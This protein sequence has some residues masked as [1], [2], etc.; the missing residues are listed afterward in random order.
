MKRIM[1]MTSLIIV[2]ITGSVLA[3]PNEP[4]G[5]R[6]YKW[7]MHENEVASRLGNDMLGKPSLILKKKS[8]PIKLANSYIS[9]AM[10]S[11][12]RLGLG[13]AMFWFFDGMLS[14]VTLHLV[15]PIL[16]NDVYE[17]RELVKKNIVK[18]YGPP[19]IMPP[20]SGK[21]KIAYVWKGK[22]TSIRLWILDD[23]TVYDSPQLL[24]NIYS[25]SLDKVEKE[26][27]DALGRNKELQGW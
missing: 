9:G 4:D 7:G 16:N 13:C 6:Q 18:L 14:N 17:L 21:D 22:V 24:L 26:Y 27:L 3:F 11:H 2:V 15:N 10:I 20:P 19:D 5:F 25:T 8:I 23:K 1:I 12:D